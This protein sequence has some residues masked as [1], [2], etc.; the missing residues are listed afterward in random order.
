MGQHQGPSGRHACSAT[1]KVQVCAIVYHGPSSPASESAWKILVLSSWL[2]LG[3]PVVNASESNCAHFLEARL[4]PLLVRTG[5]LSGPWCVLNATLLLS[6]ATHANQ[7]PNRS[8]PQSCHSCPIRRT[9]T[10]PDCSQ[11]RSPCPSH[12]TDST[13]DQESLST[14]VSN[15]FLSQV[16]ELIPSTLRRMPRLSEPGPLGMRAEHWY[17]FGEQDGDSN[18]SVQVVAHIGSCCSS[19]FCVTVPQIWP[20]DAARQTHW[21]TQTAPHDVFSPQAGP[22]VSHG[23]Q[24]GIGECAGPLQYGVG[25]LDGANTMIKT[26]QYLT[27]DD[28]NSSPC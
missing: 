15:L 21:W 16:A 6:S 26:I 13:R 24:K 14:P 12:S 25:R 5:L 2:L 7:L 3:R 10:R 4:D 22:P 27:E 23:G 20:S 8:S 28:S 19:P 18:L 11:E 1:A 9:R 17:D